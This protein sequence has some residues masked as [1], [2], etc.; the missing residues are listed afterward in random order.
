MWSQSSFSVSLITHRPIR[1]GFFCLGIDAVR[2][3]NVGRLGLVV[4]D[5]V[6]DLGRG[7]VRGL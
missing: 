1:G 3:L 5:C 4:G 2:R 6:V 7:F